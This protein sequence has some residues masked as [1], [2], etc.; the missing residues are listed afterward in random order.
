MINAV[1]VIREPGRLKPMIWHEFQLPELPRP[2]DYLTISGPDDRAPLGEDLV[3]RRVW[4]LLD[5]PAAGTSAGDEAAGQL[6]E[7]FVECDLGEGPYSSAAWREEVALAR[8]CGA[9]VEV[10]EVGRSAVGTTPRPVRESQ[11]AGDSSRGV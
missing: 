5:R 4:W 10:F 7:V 9:P 8:A 6:V 1:I 2:G 3:V 11:S